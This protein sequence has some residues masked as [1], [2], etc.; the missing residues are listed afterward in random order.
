[1]KRIT[2]C[3]AAA[4]LA[5]VFTACE[6]EF[7]KFEDLEF[8]SPAVSFICDDTV[9]AADFTSIN[10]TLTNISEF[11]IDLFNDPALYKKAGKTWKLTPFTEVYL[12][13]R[14]D[15][16]SKPIKLEPGD[17]FTF[18][19]EPHIFD[20]KLT[21]GE[22]RIYVFFHIDEASTLSDVAWADL[23]LSNKSG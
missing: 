15:F 12:Y 1:M 8:S 2:A 9:Y 17:S 6:S 7:F 11:P 5:L 14:F 4:L 16:A 3:I 22:Y 10:A 13:S 21:K 23:T 18:T 20:V 19:L